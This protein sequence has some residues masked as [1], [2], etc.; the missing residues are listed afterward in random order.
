MGPIRRLANQVQSGNVG[1]Y[2]PVLQAELSGILTY[3]RIS[4]PVFG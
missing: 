3:A 4:T 2:A 1:V